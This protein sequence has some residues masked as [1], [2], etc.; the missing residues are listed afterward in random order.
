M[1]LGRPPRPLPAFADTPAGFTE[2]EEGEG[3]ADD[4]VLGLT[5]LKEDLSRFGNSFSNLL[6]RVP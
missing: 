6:L 1:I 3:C 5:G 2:D 4:T